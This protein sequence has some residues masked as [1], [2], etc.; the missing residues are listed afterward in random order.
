MLSLREFIDTAP[1]TLLYIERFQLN[2]IVPETFVMT[3]KDY[4]INKNELRRGDELFIAKECPFAF[5]FLDAFAEMI[6]EK[7]VDVNW[8]K[9][10]ISEMEDKIDVRKIED[11]IN[12]VLDKHKY[13][14]ADEYVENDLW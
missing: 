8:A 11:V 6:E 2:K 10:V 4:I 1:K 13:Y 14:I 5:S 7:A 3:V 12:K 9:D